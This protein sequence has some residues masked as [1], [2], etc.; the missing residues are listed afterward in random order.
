[1]RAEAAY[2]RAEPIREITR[3]SRPMRPLDATPH[4]TTQ[5]ARLWPTIRRLWP[6]IWP[7][8]RADLRARIFGAL[9][10]LVLAKLA[11]IAVPYA[12]KWA[13]DALTG[14]SVADLSLAALIGGPV[15][16]TIFY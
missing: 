3:I 16:L 5:D 4:A 7:H 15:A 12:F 11:T 1:M 10:L 14:H 9:A 8:R 6:Y 13:T 2:M